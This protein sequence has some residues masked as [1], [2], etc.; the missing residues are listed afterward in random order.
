MKPGYLS[1]DTW[2]ALC[3]F[4]NTAIKYMYINAKMVSCKGSDIKNKAKNASVVFE[5]QE[6]QDKYN[7]I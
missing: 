2:V 1:V 3:E 6:M 4:M 5:E 7:S